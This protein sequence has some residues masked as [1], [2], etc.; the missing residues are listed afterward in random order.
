MSGL[1][2]SIQVLPLVRKFLSKHY[3][4][5]SFQ[6][7]AINNPFAAFLLNSLDSYP[8]KDE[9]KEFAE[10]TDTLSVSMTK[11]QV[12]YHGYGRH[13]NQQ[14]VVSFNRFVRQT[15]MQV[16]AREMAVRVEMGQGVYDAARNIL[17]R[18]DLSEDDLGFDSLVRYYYA[19]QKT[20]NELSV[21]A[22]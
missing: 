8:S 15:F 2:Q 14:K 9:I 7:S 1:T 10:L 12:R 6:L 13:F 19:Y 20:I 4:I 21:A 17:K 22:W 16:A 11:K 18:Y 3:N 5:D